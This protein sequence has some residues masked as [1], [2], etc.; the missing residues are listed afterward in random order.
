VLTS[1]NDVN[2]TGANPR[3]KILTTSSVRAAT[4]GRL[5]SRPVDERVYAQPLYVGGVGGKRVV[6]V[7]TEHNSVYAFDADDT[8]PSAPPLWTRSFGQPVSATDTGC[9]LLGP[10]TPGHRSG[11]GGC[12]TTCAAASNAGRTRTS[13]TPASSRQ[14]SSIR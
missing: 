12:H 7:A 9:G 8:R 10:G 5:F 2:C 13:A 3:G 6:F 14:N 11:T 1:R 4:F